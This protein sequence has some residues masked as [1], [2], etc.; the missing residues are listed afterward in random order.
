MSDRVQNHHAKKLDDP[1]LLCTHVSVALTS[2]RQ[3][4]NDMNGEEYCFVDDVEG[5]YCCTIC[6]KV[7]TPP[8]LY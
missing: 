4:A 5:D 2:T 1:E 8:L 6:G 3:M 7:T